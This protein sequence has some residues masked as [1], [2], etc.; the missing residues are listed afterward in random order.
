M[1]MY[2]LS[3]AI[4]L[5]LSARTAHNKKS[6][7]YSPARL[8]SETK[9]QTALVD[10]GTCSPKN[11]SALTVTLRE[12]SAAPHQYIAANPPGF[13]GNLLDFETCPGI[14]DLKKNLGF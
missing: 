4:P 8:H 3:C 11:R 9:K 14:L 1:I 7:K 2:I 10:Q 12:R 6:K 13:P 5:I